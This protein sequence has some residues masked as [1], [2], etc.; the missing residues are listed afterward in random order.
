MHEPGLQYK[1]V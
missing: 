1:P